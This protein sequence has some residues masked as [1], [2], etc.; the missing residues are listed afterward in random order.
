VSDNLQ[1]SD[2]FAA[3]Y[4]ELPS[5]A[6]VGAKRRAHI[7]RVTALLSAWAAG[8]RLDRASANEWIDAGRLHDSLREAPEDELRRITGDKSSPVGLLHGPA[9][10]IR[11][12]QEGETRAGLLDAIRYHTV[13]S[14]NW[15]S[16]GKAL[17]M[18]DY[19]E[20]GRKFLHEDR[21]FLASQVPHAFEGVFRQ[22][23]RFRLEWSIREGNFI[24]PETVALW[25]EL[26]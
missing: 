16:T 25:N 17:Y 13:G 7:G 23:V 5:W 20:P 12:A 15:A 10:A 4:V 9:A 21:E 8:M 6:Q 14:A 22:V 1:D 2:T 18:A 24:Y 19:L 3:P 26:R 11:L